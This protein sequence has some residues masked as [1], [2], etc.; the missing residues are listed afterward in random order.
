MYLKN[1]LPE[2]M[3]FIRPL[4]GDSTVCL[5]AY[6]YQCTPPGQGKVSWEKGDWGK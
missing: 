6:I 2:S 4:K 3:A 5:P 1:T